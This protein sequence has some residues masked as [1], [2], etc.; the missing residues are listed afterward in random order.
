MGIQTLSLSDKTAV[1]Y[2]DFSQLL[3]NVAAALSENGADVALIT[4]DSKSAQRYCQN[5]MDL[6]E[7]SERYGRS[8]AIEWSGKVETESRDAFSRSAEI[9]GS[10]D[11][12]V[13]ASLCGLKFPEDTADISKIEKSFSDAFAKS[14]KMTESALEFIRGRSKARLLYLVNELDLQTLQAS[15]PGLIEEFNEF[16]K[17]T[18][19]ETFREQMTV[20]V[21]SLG[22]TEQYLL[23]KFPKAKSIRE[24][25][26]IVQQKQAHARL[27]EYAE[28]SS[29]LSF[30]A[31]PLSSAVNGQVIHVNHGMVSI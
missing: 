22:I 21:I 1:V 24:A 31:S 7:V 18:C 29:V 16:I 2:G 30:F 4:N 25:L 17:H 13:D 8:A 26:T 19:A 12:F 5:L 20:N 14:R 27:T 23:N 6:R 9:F 10:I 11:I 15:S 28:V 3:Q